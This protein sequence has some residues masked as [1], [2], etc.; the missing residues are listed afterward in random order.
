MLSSQNIC[1]NPCLQETD[2]LVQG[3]GM[4]TLNFSNRMSQGLRESCAES[5]FLRIKTHRGPWVAPLVKLLTLGFG[6]GRDLAIS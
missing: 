3:F 4:P 5:G 2:C 1:Y 6:S